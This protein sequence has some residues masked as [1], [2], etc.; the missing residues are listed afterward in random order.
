MQGRIISKVWLET[1]EVPRP[2]NYIM[3]FQ[4]INPGRPAL[5]P[6]LCGQP[7]ICWGLKVACMVI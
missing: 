1:L 5:I 3:A 6:C 4:V 7:H 2:H